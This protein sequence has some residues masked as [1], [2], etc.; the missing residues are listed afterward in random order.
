MNHEKTFT[1]NGVQVK[2]K[3]METEAAHSQKL[4]DTPITF[5]EAWVKKPGEREERDGYWSLGRW[6]DRP[7]TAAAKQA[8]NQVIA[9]RKGKET[10]QR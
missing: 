2:V 8:I 10:N 6:Y 1:I 4:N 3:W 7:E 9:S 5:I